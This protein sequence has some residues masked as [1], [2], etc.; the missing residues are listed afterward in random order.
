MMKISLLEINEGF[1]CV[2]VELADG[3]SDRVPKQLLEKLKTPFFQ[4]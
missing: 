2:L 3:N 4:V 1:S